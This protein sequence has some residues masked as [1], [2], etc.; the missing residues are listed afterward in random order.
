MRID[1]PESYLSIIAAPFWGKESESGG[2][3]IKGS[4]KHRR[5][6]DLYPDNLEQNA[7]SSMAAG[8]ER[9]SMLFSMG[10]LP[11]GI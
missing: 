8:N 10:V 4:R 6:N 2:P 3:G 9:K 11:S 1:R 7:K 5:F